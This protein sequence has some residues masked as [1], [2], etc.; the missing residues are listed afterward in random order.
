[1]SDEWFARVRELRR[2]KIFVKKS[3][4]MA[5]LGAFETMLPNGEIIIRNNLC[6]ESRS[7]ESYFVKHIPSQEFRPFNE[8]TKPDSLACISSGL[9][10][11]YCNKRPAV[12]LTFPTKVRIARKRG[13][14][15]WYSQDIQYYQLRKAKTVYKSFPYNNDVRLWSSYTQQWISWPTE[16]EVTLFWMNESLE[17]EE[18]WEM[19]LGRPAAKPDTPALFMLPESLWTSQTLMRYFDRSSRKPETDPRLKR[20]ISYRRYGSGLRYEFLCE[21]THTSCNTIRVW[22]PYT[23]LIGNP[24]YVCCLLREY[25]WDPSSYRKKHLKDLVLSELS[26]TEDDSDLNIVKR[27]FPEYPMTKV[28]KK[29]C[30]KRKRKN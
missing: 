8:T 6:V 1:M 18:E 19:D 2:C 26:D 14:C 11:D 23:S 17:P 21:F 24:E 29:P 9:W 28:D 13:I 22:L 7:D 30:R 12:V 20:F 25:G 4:K 10:D 15:L 16:K 27:P 5:Y 3:R